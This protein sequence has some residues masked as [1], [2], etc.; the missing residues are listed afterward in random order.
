MK[1]EIVQKNIRGLQ[2]R[3]GYNGACT[4]VELCCKIGFVKST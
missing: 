3:G 4:V 2:S 1:G